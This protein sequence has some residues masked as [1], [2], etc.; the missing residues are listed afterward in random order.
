MQMFSYHSA[1][2]CPT[3]SSLFIAVYLRIVKQLSV[4]LLFDHVELSD[5]SWLIYG[6][7]A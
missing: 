1:Y 3:F 5:S 2:F 4:R 6:S 7:S